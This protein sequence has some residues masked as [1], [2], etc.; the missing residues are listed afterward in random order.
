MSGH[1]LEKKMILGIP[2]RPCKGNLQAVS[3]SEQNRSRIPCTG[4]LKPC[5][6]QMTFT[7]GSPEWLGTNKQVVGHCIIVILLQDTFDSSRHAL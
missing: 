4:T 5:P 7:T 1:N 3:K 6:W 2:L